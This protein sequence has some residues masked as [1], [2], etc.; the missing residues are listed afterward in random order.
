MKV[1]ELDK[2]IAEF[3]KKPTAERLEAVNEIRGVVSSIDKEL[4]KIEKGGQI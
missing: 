4:S 3:H 1:V 2:Q